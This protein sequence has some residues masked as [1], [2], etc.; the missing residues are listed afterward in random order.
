MCLVL[1][2]WN[3]HPRYPLVIAANRDEDHARPAAPA[4]WWAD[5]PDVLGGRDLVGGGSWLSIRR[6]GRYALVLNQPARPPAPERSA[7][8]GHLVREWVT[9][10]DVLAQGYLQRVREREAGYAGFTLVVGSAAGPRGPEGFVAP[11]GP[12]GARWRFAEGI[13]ALSNSARE[14]PL[15]KALWLERQAQALFADD[16]VDPLQLFDVLGRRDPVVPTPEAERIGRLRA[17]PFLVGHRYGT[18]A[19]TVVAVDTSGRCRF[20]ERRFRA[21]GEPDGETAVEFDLEG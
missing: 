10:D 5:A 2:A 9:A 12:A 6:N 11:A 20:V 13:T 7:S 16:A 1:V 18:R 15:P 19:S 17:T 14:E 21:Q 8:R 4:G 3:I